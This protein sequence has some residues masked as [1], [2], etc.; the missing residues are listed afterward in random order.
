MFNDRINNLINN[1]IIKNKYSKLSIG[2]IIDDKKYYFNYDNNG[3]SENVYEYEIGSISKTFT[4]HMVMKYVGLGLIDINESVGKYL[5]LVGNYP[6]I[7][8]LLTHTAGYGHLT[9]IEFTLKNVIKYHKKNLYEIINS[10]DVIKALMK[11]KKKKKYNYSYSDFNYGILA[12]MLEK[13][14]ERSFNELFEEFIKEDLKLDNTHTL[15][16]YI[17]NTESVFRKKIIPR[18]NWNSDNPY[19]SAGGIC[20][21]V[22]DMVKYMEIEMYSNMEYIKNCHIVNEDTKKRKD[23]I[24]ICPGWHAY[25]NGNHLWHVGGVGCY[26]SSVIISKNKRIGVIGLGNS[27]GKRNYNIHYL[28]KMLYSYL[29]RNRNKL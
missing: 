15:I 6:T 2:I 16:D 14:C 11:R 20:S 21:N 24:L 4:A 5:G 8:E 23:R 1:Y 18:W 7:Y 25:K 3:L 19:I 10:N 17:P 22:F 9:P 29:S 28:V 26:R 12:C 27:C 13:V